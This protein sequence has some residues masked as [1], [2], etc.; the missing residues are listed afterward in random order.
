MDDV[1]DFL[2]ASAFHGHFK[3]Q[4][5]AIGFVRGFL[6]EY[7]PYGHL[8]VEASERVGDKLGYDAV[9]EGEFPIK[10]ED[11][12]DHGFFHFFRSSS[13]APLEP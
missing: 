6:A 11:R 2:R 13:I 1:L 3:I 12:P 8:I 9:G 7:V 5:D 10:A 4:L